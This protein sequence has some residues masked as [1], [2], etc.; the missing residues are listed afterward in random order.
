MVVELGL[1]GVDYLE[2]SFHCVPV[3]VFGSLSYLCFRR[4]ISM[5]VANTTSRRRGV[6]SC[7]LYPPPCGTP[8]LAV[9]S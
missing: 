2:R 3:S 5:G 7:R 6:C 1:N 8:E 4:S 9:D